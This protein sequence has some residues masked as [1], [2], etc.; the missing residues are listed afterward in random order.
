VVS[1]GT[2]DGAV[3]NAFR[4]WAGYKQDPFPILDVTADAGG[5]YAGGGGLGGHLVVWNLDG[6]LPQPVYQT[7]G[8]V[9][10]VSLAGPTLYAGGH[11]TNYC[12]GNTGSGRPYLCSNPLSRRKALEVTLSTGN[13]TSWAPR[14][15]SPHGVIASAVDPSTGSLWMAGDFTKVGT[16]A[17][18]HLAHFAS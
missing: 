5:V 10:T 11:F 13:L 7:D 9:Q 17:V 15:N 14:F 2:A 1:L 6:S 16:K 8:G 18:D 3:A 12:L 4:P